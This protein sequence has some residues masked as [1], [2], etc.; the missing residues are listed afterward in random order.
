MYNKNFFQNVN[1]PHN[2]N[3]INFRGIIGKISAIDL[4]LCHS[5]HSEINR[6]ADIMVIGNRERCF[7]MNYCILLCVIMTSMSVL[8]LGV[9]RV[10]SFIS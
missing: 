5:L 10:G 8:D 7:C 2:F 3:L 4:K 9:I 6:T 1:D